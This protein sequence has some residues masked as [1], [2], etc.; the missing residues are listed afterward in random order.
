ME[1]DISCGFLIFLILFLD[2]F[3]IAYSGWSCGAIYSE[4][5]LKWTP[6]I[7]V[8]LGLLCTST[9]LMV[10]AAITYAFWSCNGNSAAQLA[11]SILTWL[12][13]LIGVIGF[14]YYYANLFPFWSHV[15]SLIAL[16]MSLAVASVLLSA[17]LKDRL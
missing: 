8:V 16:G 15:T 5:C 6:V 12:A 14:S 9:I 7:P 2:I 3:S 4:A 13:S 17:S 10:F 11:A 1:K